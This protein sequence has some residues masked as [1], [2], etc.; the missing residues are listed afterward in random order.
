VNEQE[1]G[2][3]SAQSAARLER[4][5]LVLAAR[6]VAKGLQHGMHRAR[7]TGG[8]S[9]FFDYKQYSHGDSIRHIDWKAYGRS[10]RLYLK[11][12]EQESRLTLGIAVDTSASM[13]YAGE[14]GA[15][16][17]KL[18]RACEIA[19]SL[20]YLACA[21]GD[22]VALSASGDDAQWSAS[23]WPA[24]ARAIKALRGFLDDADADQGAD[25]F[26]RSLAQRPVSCDVLVILTD[27]IEEPGIIAKALRAAAGVRGRDFVFVQVLTRDELQLPDAGLA[28]FRDPETGEQTTA[29][30][31]R[32]AE[33]YHEKISAHLREVERLVRSVRGQYHLAVTADEPI[34]SVRAVVRRGAV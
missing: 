22:R 21:Q 13:R 26:T 23:G 5:P 25:S 2:I 10:D 24:F 28:R 4:E 15:F 1:P 11:R 18:H 33:M 17:S 30:T 31:A 6:A 16:P 32:V 20:A 3:L 27:G 9:E 29:D 12:Y 14:S 19:A 7:G 8:S 34:D